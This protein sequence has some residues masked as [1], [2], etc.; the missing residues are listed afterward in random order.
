MRNCSATHQRRKTLMRRISFNLTQEQVRN[1][2]KT[3][4]R[5]LGWRNVKVGEVLRAVDRLRV[6]N[7]ETLAIIEVVS[8]RRETLFELL[9]AAD[10]SGYDG[11]DKN[12]YAI[13]EMEREGFPG[14]A[15]LAFV[16]LLTEGN[17][18]SPHAN[19]VE[20]T[21]IEFRYLDQVGLDA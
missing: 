12:P 17:G 9:K 3:V 8:A 14:M 5:R 13:S 11:G 20:V 10:G 15:P 19:N 1:R 16:A 21:R 2:T 18:L 4:T 7:A 6:K